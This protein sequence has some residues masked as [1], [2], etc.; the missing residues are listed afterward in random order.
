MEAEIHA[1]L[2]ADPRS[3]ALL[4][5]K[6]F[7]RTLAGPLYRSPAVFFQTTDHVCTVSPDNPGFVM[8]K[9]RTASTQAKAAESATVSGTPTTSTTFPG[10]VATTTATAPSTAD[11]A[12]AERYRALLQPTSGVE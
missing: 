1:L 3:G 9:T 11:A 2:S 10:T 5:G 12:E 8:L 4:E 6:N 7:V